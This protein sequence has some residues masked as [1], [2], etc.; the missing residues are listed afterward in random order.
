LVFYATTVFLASAVLLVLVTV[1]AA[2]V[3]VATNARGGFD[4]PCYKE[5]QYYCIRVEDASRDAPFGQ[6]RDLVLDHLV[7]GTNHETEPGMLL[8]PALFAARDQ[9]LRDQ[10]CRS[11]LSSRSRHA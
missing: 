11:G 7:H 2:A 5:S 1:R 6:A 9:H 4:N 10:V 8:A 3:V